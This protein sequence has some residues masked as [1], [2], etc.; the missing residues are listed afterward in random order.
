MTELEKAM[1]E[2]AWEHHN[3]VWRFDED[4]CHRVDFK[5]GFKAALK[6]E[7]MKLTKEVSQ[8]IEAAK[9]SNWAGFT[10]ALKPFES[11]GE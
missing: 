7:H 5:I 6:P 1:E 10:E 9:Y 4:S 2:A 3:K 11:E 8:L